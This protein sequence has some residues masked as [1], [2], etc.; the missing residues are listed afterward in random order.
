M[1]VLTRNGC[2]ILAIRSGSASELKMRC[3]L[4][5]FQTLCSHVQW[6]WWTTCAEYFQTQRKLKNVETDKRR[7]RKL[8]WL[9]SPVQSLF[10]RKAL[11]ARVY[12]NYRS[13]SAWI[14]WDAA[15]AEEFPWMWPA[16]NRRLRLAGWVWR[17]TGGCSAVATWLWEGL[18]RCTGGRQSRRRAPEI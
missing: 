13:Y 15:L 17:M 9:K 7:Q 6:S 8:K 11:H 18:S 16:Q 3:P 14:W 12:A 5:A 10:R 1:K 4:L 2:R